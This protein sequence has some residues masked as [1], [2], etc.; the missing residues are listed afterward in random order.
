MA[1]SP[2]SSL[3]L[4]AALSVLAGTAHAQEGAVAVT[5][6]APPDLF[7]M[8]TAET[9]LPDDLWKDASP[10]L[11][12]QVLPTLGAKPLSPAF[13]AFARRV[14]A[15]GAH[16]PKGIGDDPEMGAARGLGLIALGEAAGAK[17]VLDRTPGLD[18]NSALAMAGAEANLIRGDDER[19]CAI[20]NALG[21]DRGGGYWLRLRAFCQQR[22]GQLDEAQLTFNLA[23]QQSQ[24][25][26]YVRMMTALLAKTPDTGSGDLRNG[27][28]FALSTTLALDIRSPAAAATASPALRPVTAPAPGDLAA[29][30]ASDWTFLR[31]A[32]PGTDFAVAA[33]AAAP[34]IASTV[35]AGGP[36]D[37]MLFL[38]AALAAGDVK[39]AQAIRGGLTGAAPQDLALID[40]ALA[41]DS[42]E[43]TDAALH[44]LVEQG[45]AAGA[46]SPLQPAA[47]VLQGLG[48]ALSP[49]DR[50]T[51]AGFEAGKST[52]SSARLALL[53]SA[54]LAG[55]KGEAALLALWIA[56]EAGAAGPAPADR[57]RIISA[58]NR[59]GLAVDA[60]AIAAEGL[61]PAPPAPAKPAAAKPAAKPVKK[62]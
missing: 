36:M 49:E 12:R 1:F 2:R 46:K 60:R 13:A 4:A 21:V 16:A 57:A 20:A 19:A 40:A 53:D 32:K 48:G 23:Q 42:G 39:T 14:L 47:V 59:A 30:Q 28:D 29:A 17:Q 31:A 55:R 43:P 35:A 41:A 11:M 34:L 62:K 5:T 58:L 61:L 52:A 37:Q 10:S 8:P 25:P 15:T 22:A 24:D 18:Q 7:S 54:A 6:L 45:A 26:A 44:T 51:F 38:R 33:R 9:G 50:A 56:G 27:I 3:A